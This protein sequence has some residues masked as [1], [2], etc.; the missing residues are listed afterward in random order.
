MPIPFYF[1]CIY[2]SVSQDQLDLIFNALKTVRLMAL[3]ER[4]HDVAV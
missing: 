4:E 2:D 1:Y 3:T